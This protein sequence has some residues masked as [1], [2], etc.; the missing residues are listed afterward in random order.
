MPEEIEKI[1]TGLLG[2]IRHAQDELNSTVMMTQTVIGEV[3]PKAYPVAGEEGLPHQFTKLTTKR[4]WA[5]FFHQKRVQMFSPCSARHHPE[6]DLLAGFTTFTPT[7]AEKNPGAETERRGFRWQRGVDRR[8][9]TSH[10]RFREENTEGSVGNT[11][12]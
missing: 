5:L 12:H 6:D 11:R 4:S 2:L 8:A 1:R 7:E 3:Y 9:A 10:H